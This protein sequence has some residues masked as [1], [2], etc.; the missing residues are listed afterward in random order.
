[1]KTVT[2]RT[3]IVVLLFITGKP[4]F[5][6]FGGGAI[7]GAEAGTVSGN[8]TVV[9]EK[10]PAV[11]RMQVD[12]L[13]KA[14]SLEEALAGLKER[15]EA[16]RAQ[17]AAFGVDK[18]SIKLGEPKLSAGKN[19]RQQQ[20]EAVLA[21]RMRSLNR[22][23]AQKNAAPSTP[24]TVSVELTAEWK[25][26]VKTIE[27]LLLATQPL[28]KKIKDAD[29]GGIKAA[30]QLSPEEQEIMEEMGEIS[31]YGDEGESKPGEP[32]FFYAALISQ[33]EEDKALGEAYQKARS[34][35][36]RLAK[37]AGY[38]LGKL[39]SI[40]SDAGSSTQE[41]EYGYSSAYYT[42]ARR[43]QAAENS[44]DSQAEAVSVLPGQVK[45]EVNVMAGF[46]LN[47]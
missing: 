43:L 1:M 37:A 17:L 25:L 30:S 5:S 12:L 35:A 38:E 8:G 16:A 36:A 40:S 46:E 31:M 28:Q 33:Q 19:D 21:E 4:V 3:L 23:G 32:V 6:Q 24:V 41:S 42:I 14:S 2:I 27:E 7:L 9:I 45:Y 44:K 22:G 13:S 29:V 10:T 39:S 11:M 18:A 20:M 26:K 34:Q 47:E 15:V